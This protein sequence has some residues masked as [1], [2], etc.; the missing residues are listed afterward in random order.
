MTRPRGSLRLR[1][2]IGAAV[3]IAAALLIAGV[4]LAH[5]FEDHVHHRFAAELGHHLDQLCLL[6]TSR[7]V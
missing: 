4:I 5:L 7:C 1:L 6:Y 3:W 2:L